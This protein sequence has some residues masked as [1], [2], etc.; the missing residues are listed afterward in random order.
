MARSRRQRLAPLPGS[1]VTAADAISTRSPRSRTS[2]VLAIAVIAA[3]AIVVGGIALW[4]AVPVFG[5]G[6]TAAIQPIAIL[7]TPDVHALLIDP[8]NPDR[9]FFG[10]HAGM[11]ESIDGG[12]TWQAG[13]LQNADAMSMAASPVD[14]TTL[15]VAG[16]NVFLV[17]RDGAR[18]WQPVEHDLPGAD[19]HAFAQDPRDPRRL[20]ALVVGAG[21]LTSA[22]GGTTWDLLPTQP[23]GVAGHAALATNGKVLYAATGAGLVS[24]SDGGTTWESRS[25]ADWTALSLAM[26]VDEENTLYAGTDS[27]VGRSVDGGLSWSELGPGDTPI[28]AL[29]VAP[30]DPNRMLIVDDRGAVYRSDDGGNSWQAPR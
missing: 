21:V 3:G 20:Y 29:A 10:S 12:Y 24:S 11:L 22:D 13:A 16:H 6:Q 25:P 17:S 26:T 1:A 19:I 30:A 7:E 28:L 18:T 4:R 5:G 2:W 23:P 9:I 14:P 8:A 27:G 15:Y